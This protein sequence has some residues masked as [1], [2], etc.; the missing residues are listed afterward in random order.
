MFLGGRHQGSH[1]TS[2]LTASWASWL[3]NGGTRDEGRNKRRQKKKAKIDILV[4][5]AADLVVVELTVNVCPYCAGERE[6]LRE[7]PMIITT[8]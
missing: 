5:T 3:D 4:N 2:W 8:I 6:T 1:S 7:N